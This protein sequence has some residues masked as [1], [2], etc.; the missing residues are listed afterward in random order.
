M[1]A[2]LWGP[3]Q[4]RSPGQQRGGGPPGCL[5]TVGSGIMGAQLKQR[6]SAPQSEWGV[7]SWLCC[8]PGALTALTS[9]YGEIPLPKGRGE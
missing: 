3:G 4:A 2:E 6:M 5:V 9:G 7:C 8:S 1:R